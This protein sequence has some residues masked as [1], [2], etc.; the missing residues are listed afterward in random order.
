M[1]KLT[2]ILLA[3]ALTMTYSCKQT[4]DTKKTKLIYPETRKD[5]SV[6]D[7]YFGTKVAD[8]YR[9]LEDDNSDET[10]AWVKA[11]QKVTNTYLHAIP[12][13]QQIIDRLTEI[14]NYERFSSPFKEADKYF[15]FRNDGLQNQSV[16]YLQDDLD[17][18][19]SIL[20]DPNGLSED[21]TLALSSMGI[22]SDGKYLA[23]GVSRG[24]SDWNEIYVKEIATGKLL[25][26]HIEWVKFSGITWHKDGF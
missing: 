18:E 11:Q 1:K 24:G 10:K 5:T 16:L 7:D 17:S 2:F 26:D 21:G 3:I 12:F 4:E 13:R 15:Y 25:D 20:L 19:A 14:Y 22:S 9:W 23:Y 8:P 6:V